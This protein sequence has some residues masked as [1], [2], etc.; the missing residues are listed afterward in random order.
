MRY[1]RPVI[2][3]SALLALQAFCA[4]R[5]SAQVKPGEPQ[6]PD[7]VVLENRRGKVTFTH[8]KHA[9]F[10]ECSGCHHASKPEKPLASP[11][12]KCSDCHTSPAAQPMKTSLRM[13]FHDTGTSSGTCLTCH[14]KAAETG[15]AA[16]LDCAECHKRDGGLP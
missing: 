12:Q 1:V 14:N 9:Q 3:G 2:L 15:K 11:R 10:G 8:R 4:S 6:G 16:P 13:A 7:T 5:V